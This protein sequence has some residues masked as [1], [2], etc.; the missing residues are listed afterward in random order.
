MTFKKKLI[1]SSSFKTQSKRSTAS[2]LK[3]TLIQASHEA[4]QGYGTNEYKAIC[5]EFLSQ[6]GS[7]EVES[8]PVVE[9]TP[10]QKAA[11][12]KK[13]KTD[14]KKADIDALI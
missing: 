7:V 13:S 1:K 3:Q 12:T 14:K 6:W 8:E 11:A 2:E 4:S 9:L 5:E 10:A